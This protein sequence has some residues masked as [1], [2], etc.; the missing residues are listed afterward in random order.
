METLDLNAKLKE[1]KQSLKDCEDLLIELEAANRTA[2]DNQK[3]VIKAAKSIVK[4]YEK[5]F[6]K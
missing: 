1:A 4:A 6:E 3:K 5:A 2:V